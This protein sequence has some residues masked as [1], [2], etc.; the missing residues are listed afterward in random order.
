MPLVLRSLIMAL[1]VG[2]AILTA[3]PRG[4][5]LE[6][7]EGE[8]TRV[9]LEAGSGQLVRLDAP[10]ASVLIADPA[11]ADVASVSPTVLW[12]YGIL[13]GVT[14]VFIV[15]A[16][17]SIL[18]NLQLTVSQS[19][20][21]VSRALSQVSP[22]GRL[23][24]SPVGENGLLLT[25]N[26]QSPAEAAD[27]VRVAGTFVPPE[28]VIN[29]SF[30]SGPT[31][32]NLR[33]TVAEVARDATR[34]LGVQWNTQFFDGDFFLEFATLGF[35]GDDLL[36]PA[37]TASESAILSRLTDGNFSASTFLSALQALDLA[38]I[39]A[40]PNLTAMSGETANFLAGGEFPIAVAQDDGAISV[41]F[42]EFGV[43]LAFT[44]T[45]LNNGRINLRVRP[46]VSSLSAEFAVDIEGFTIPSLVTRRADTTVELSSGQSFAI[47]GL[48]DS[49]TIESAEEVPF[50][51]DLPIIGNLFSSDEF[52]RN[53]TELVIVVTPYLVEPVS[54]P[55]DVL[56]PTDRL[57]QPTELTIG[58]RIIGDPPSTTV[59][60]TPDVEPAFAGGRIDTQAGFILE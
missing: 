26:A 23:R 50:L 8:E 5:A 7:L 47:A 10:A 3:A 46:E 32:I 44:P 24:V 9:A 54:N 15:D 13:P 33:V 14:N 49:R 2:A 53:E 16:N 20:Q 34:N 30:V 40:E 42:R 19:V 31:Q 22:G 12:V 48:F 27:A 39:L 55:R 1:I 21:Q 43:S 28:N 29:R 60:S 59:L 38:T 4:M 11:I 37:I 6:I 51:V 35:A 25:G 52:Q 58:Q 57:S 45:L 41:Q 17:D 36:E 18:A 56:L